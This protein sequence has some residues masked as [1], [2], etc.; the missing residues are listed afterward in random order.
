MFVVINFLHSTFHSSVRIQYLVFGIQHEDAAFMLYDTILLKNLLSRLSNSFKVSFHCNPARHMQH[1]N[2]LDAKHWHIS[3]FQFHYALWYLNKCCNSFIAKAYA[4][5]SQ[6]TY[7]NLIILKS[8]EIFKLNWVEYSQVT[9]KILLSYHP[10]FFNQLF[11]YFEFKV[12]SFFT[13]KLYLK[14]ESI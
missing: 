12:I 1:I 7:K 9:R 5:R 14:E 8:L 6:S 13:Y 3:I 2:Q 11:T 10:N 4:N